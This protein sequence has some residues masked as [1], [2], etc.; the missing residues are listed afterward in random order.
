MK[1]KKKFLIQKE[2]FHFILWYFGFPL[3]ILLI[4]VLYH[5]T[6]QLQIWGILPSVGALA[7][8]IIF[9]FFHYIFF[10]AIVIYL[11]LI[12]VYIFSCKLFKFTMHRIFAILCIVVSLIIC[13]LLFGT[14][15]HFPLYSL[16]EQ[17]YVLLY[18]I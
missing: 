11:V 7:G 12:G 16:Y 10:D 3:G 18:N 1:Q 15:I 6:S 9:G 17:F 8:T 5:I 2:T 4:S 13:R 14:G